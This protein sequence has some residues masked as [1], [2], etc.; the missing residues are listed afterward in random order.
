M[1]E[2]IERCGGELN[3]KFRTTRF[4]NALDLLSAYKAEFD[5]IFMDI[6][7]P[8]MDSKKHPDK[9]KPGKKR[10]GESA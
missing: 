1:S 3:E 7:L 4:V 8:G 10:K 9:Y 6:E 5:I 2:Y